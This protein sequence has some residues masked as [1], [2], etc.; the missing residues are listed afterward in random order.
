[1]NAI[2]GP[3]SRAAILGLGPAVPDLDRLL[4]RHLAGACPQT[5]LAA[6]LDSE[7]QRLAAAGETFAPR[8]TDLRRASPAALA[9]F[10]A[11]LR[12]AQDDLYGERFAA[13]R[14]HLRRAAESL[15]QM[16]RAAATVDEQAAAERE[17]GAVIAAFE[18]ASCR[19]LPALR[20]P[21]RLLA[22]SRDLLDAA[23]P[24]KAGFQARAARRLMARLLSCE[25]GGGAAGQSSGSADSGPSLA[26]RLARLDGELRS[27]TAGCGAQ[28]A[29]IQRLAAAGHTYL[30]R[31]LV[32]DLDQQ[33]LG[34]FRRRPIG[35]GAALQD[36]SDTMRRA[37]DLLP[38][39]AT[40]GGASQS[41]RAGQ[42]DD[43][44]R[45]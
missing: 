14:R 18:L 33:L 13:A 8:R 7:L 11:S 28:L 5:T 32:D 38:R 9:D 30:A 19:D 35:S 31:W 17:L 25:E 4:R 36:L 45:R 21:A 16:A 24:E 20:I 29:A 1:V 41:G 2:P 39:L 3:P 26:A 15:R 10:T 42:P 22:R 12:T 23:Q 6:A 43:P 34:R 44:A 40:F 27:A 37:Q